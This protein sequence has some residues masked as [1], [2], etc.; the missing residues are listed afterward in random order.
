MPYLFF[1]NY[2]TIILLQVL[3]VGSKDFTLVGRPLLHKDLVK[4]TA[5]VVEKNYTVPTIQCTY[6]KKRMKKASEFSSTKKKK[7]KCKFSYLL[8]F[9]Y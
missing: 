5:K 2:L 9:F 7:I 8:K 4:I 3:L 1:L 6:D